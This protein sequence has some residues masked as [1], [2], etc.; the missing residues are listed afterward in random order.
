MT[1]ATKPAAAGSDV[2]R[3]L[4]MYRQMIAIRLFE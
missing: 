2:Q 3:L 1:I 4:Q